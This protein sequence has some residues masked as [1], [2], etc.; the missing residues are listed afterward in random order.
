[1]TIRYLSLAGEFNEQALPLY[2]SRVPAGFPSPADDYIEGRLDLNKYLIQKPAATFFARAEGDSMI[3]AGIQPGDLLI[4]DRSARPVHN[5]IVVAALDGELTCKILDTHH[6][7]LRSVN[8]HYPP[9]KILPGSDFS[10]EGVVL[11]SIHHHVRV[12]GL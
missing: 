4:V 1:M 6:R 5:S 2:A 11:H 7:C 10:I 3:G 8:P 9:I 12:S